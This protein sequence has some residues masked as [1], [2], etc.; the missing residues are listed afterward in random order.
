MWISAR[1]FVA[2]VVAV[3]VIAAPA[4]A[5]R[6]PPYKLFVLHY[7]VHIQIGGV[8]ANPDFLPALNASYS[9]RF[10]SA[11]LYALNATEGLE[12][13]SK[14]LGF[15]RGYTIET[16]YL[17]NVSR[18]LETVVIEYDDGTGARNGTF[19][20]TGLVGTSGANEVAITGGTGTFRG[21]DGYALISFQRVAPNNI[22]TFRHESHFL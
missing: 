17:A 8:N 15:S 19:V 13:T 9:A 16:S 21:A 1:V 6:R 22:Y 18:G 12:P 20:L 3:A 11:V 5:W 7:Y 14:K 2:L 4:D 10:G